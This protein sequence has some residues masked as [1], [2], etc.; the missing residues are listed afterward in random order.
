[1]LTSHP[2]SSLRGLER[3]AQVSHLPH[4]RASPVYV[5]EPSPTGL[6]YIV[7]VLG[8]GPPPA[9][10][11]RVPA[12]QPQHTV[13]SIAYQ[14]HPFTLVFSPQPRLPAVP[15]SPCSHERSISNGKE[16][17]G[18]HG[19]LVWDTR[20]LTQRLSSPRFFLGRVVGCHARDAGFLFH[21]PPTSNI[22]SARPAR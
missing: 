5:S 6:N 11:S 1:M 14:L 7:P 9:P 17:W 20:N 21:F 18:K 22:W 3:E 19:G 13:V 12:F 2:Y 15:R 16:G 4:G 10:P 8:W